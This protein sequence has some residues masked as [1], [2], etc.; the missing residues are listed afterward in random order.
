MSRK[1]LAAVLAAGIAATTLAAA[2]AAQADPS[3]YHPKFVP[4]ATDIVGVGSD[5]TQFLVADLADG[6]YVDQ[7]RKVKAKKFYNGYNTGKK[8][9]RIASFDAFKP[10]TK[11]TGDTI[12]LRA[13]QRGIAR[14]DGSGA[15]IK[16]LQNSPRLAGTTH[17]VIDF[18]RSSRAPKDGEQNLAFL[19]FAVDSVTWARNGAAKGNA[20]NLSQAQLK[21]IFNCS[22]T[23]WK[24]VGGANLPIRPM[25]PQN[26]SGTRSF[27]LSKLGITDPGAA[28]LKCWKTVQEHDPAP[29][30]ATKG[31][32]GPM[33][34][35][36]YLAPRGANMKGITLG[37][38]D[39]KSPIDRKGQ[40]NTIFP[41]SRD[42]YNVVKRTG[43]TATGAVPSYLARIFGDGK[44]RAGALGGTPFVCGKQGQAIIV[45]N[46]FGVSKNCG[47]AA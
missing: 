29:I 7:G 5:T 18:A 20:T 1:T 43:G 22:I 14:P 12:V 39:K 25:V 26:G 37:G 35:A 47:K 42:V 44:G 24:Q 46:G 33:S 45:A 13:G 41:F 21:G 10:G 27:F 15:G 9:G 2:P 6:T 4:S 32:I 8:A 11:I 31:A 28:G 3:Q 19:K 23:N 40:L 38:V 30:A 16:A 17:D 36:R 34:V